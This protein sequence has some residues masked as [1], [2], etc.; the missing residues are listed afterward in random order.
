MPVLVGTTSCENDPQSFISLCWGLLG[1]D[2]MIAVTRRCLVGIDLEK[3][4]AVVAES[5]TP[6]QGLGMVWG[7]TKTHQRREVPIPKFL[8][9]DL[10]RHLAGRG[11]NDLVFVWPTVR[12][13]ARRG[14]RRDGCGSQSRTRLDTCAAP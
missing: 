2:R 5:V 4:R 6:V 7:T 1:V 10:A 13:P 9:D 8:V 3:R 11:Q 14:R 12:E